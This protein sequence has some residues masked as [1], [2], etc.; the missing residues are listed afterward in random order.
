[1][2]CGSRSVYLVTYSQVDKEKVE[3]KEEFATMV[4]EEFKD[5]NVIQWICAEEKHQES[6][7]HYHLAIKLDRVKR[8]KAVRQRLEEK[9]KVCVNFSDHHNNYYTAYKYVKKDGDF[10]TSENHTEYIGSPKTSK[11]S[12]CRKRGLNEFKDAPKVAAKRTTAKI[13][14]VDLYQTVVKQNIKSDLQL[15]ALARQEIQDGK[16]NFANF[17][18]RKT[19][20]SRKEIIKTAWKI[21]N[22]AEILAREDKNRLEILYDHAEKEC[23]CVVKGEWKT[24][25]TE[26][27]QNNGIDQSVFTSAIMMCLEKGRGKKQNVIIVGP[28]NCGKTFLLKPLLSI[29]K[30][31]VNPATGTFAWVGVENSEVV[32]L[33]DFRWSERIMPWADFLNLL[34]GAPIHISAPKTH[35]AEDILWSKDT[36]IFCTS[37]AVIR[38]YN[39]GQLDE[40][41]TEMMDSRWVVFKLQHQI[42]HARDVVTCTRCFTEF[43]MQIQE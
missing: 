4:V 40:I 33:N 21:H 15:C 2:D 31:F 17:I 6:G 34:E 42:K 22:S 38:K 23:T 37:D 12:N 28:T 14:I 27:L 11:A 20:K 5:C 16:Q 36:P 43:L 41:E 39:C 35:Y 10:I 8:W 29:Y 7:T 3:S 24:S 19:E 26:I 30:T 32:F 18:L 13:D 9:Y 1:M 25:A